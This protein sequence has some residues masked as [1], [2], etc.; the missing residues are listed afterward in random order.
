MWTASAAANTLAIQD[1][2]VTVETLA[3][4]VATLSGRSELHVTSGGDPITGTIIHLNSPDSW[5]FFNRIQPFTVSGSFLGRIRINGAAAATST[6]VRVVQHGN[7]TVVI[8]HGPSFTPLTLFT[9]GRFAGSSAKVPLYTYHNNSNLGALA[10]NIHSFRLKRGYMATMA[11]NENGTGG[12]RVFIAQDDDLDITVMPADL[13][14]NLRFVRVFPW[15]WVSK[16]GWAGNNDSGNPGQVN[17]M[18]FYNWNNNENSGFNREYSPIRQTRWWPSYDI[19]N[20][21]QN[22]TH[23]L[24]FNEPDSPDQADMTVTQAINEWPNLMRSG[25]RLGSPAPTDGGL[26]WLYQFLDQANALNYRVDF[27]AVHFYR[28]GQT[29]T[30]LYNWLRDIHIRTGKPLWVTEWNNGANWTCCAPSSYEQQATIIKSFSEKMDE[31]PFVER[32][33][34]YNWLNGNRELIVNGNLT[35][36]GVAYR[37]HQSPIGHIDTPPLR[38]A[39]VYD[40]QVLQSNSVN[41]EMSYDNNSNW[42]TGIGQ[43]LGA[44]QVIPLS[45]FKTRLAEAAAKG[46][47]GVVDFER[48]ALHDG[49]TSGGSGF[50]AL[51]DDGRKS[52]DFTNQSA[53][54]GNYAIIGPRADRTAISGENSLSRS[55]NPNFD[56]EISNPRGLIRQEK[57][58]AAGLTALG[59]NGVSGTNFFRFTAWYTNGSTSGSTSVRRQINTNTGRGSADTFAGIA[60]PPG[61]WITRITLTS[62]NG[63]FTSIDDL[64]FITSLEPDLL[65]APGGTI[66]GPGVWDNSVTSWTNGG[67]SLAWPGGTIATFADSAGSVD[68]TANVPAVQGLVFETDG[69][70]LTGSGSLSFDSSAAIHVPSGLTTIHTALGG[71]IPAKTGSGTLALGGANNFSAGVWTFGATNTNSGQ[72]RLIHPDALGGL[73]LVRLRGT[74]GPAVSGIELAGGHTFSQ[75]IH[76]WGRQDPGGGGFVLRNLSGNN[77]WNGDITIVDGGG[78]YGFVSAAGRLT[79]G[80]RITSSYVHASFGNRAVP[81]HGAGETRITGSLVNGSGGSNASLRLAVTKNDNGLLSVAPGAV[82][83]VQTFT[84]NA[85]SL[86]LDSPATFAVGSMLLNATMPITVDGDA[87]F[88]FPVNGEGSITKTGSGTLT[89]AAANDFAPDAGTFT[90]GSGATNVGFLRL[91]HPQA[92]GKHTRIVLN[93]SQGGT[94]GLELEG[95]HTFNIALETTGRSSSASTGFAL[96][97]LAGDNI[98]NGSFTITSTGGNYG[99][100]S[101]SGLLTI[102]GDITSSVASTLGSRLLQFAGDGN[103]RLTGQVRKGGSFAAQNLAVSHAGPG[104]LI[105]AAGG[106]YSGSTQVNGGTLQIDGLLTSSSVTVGSDGRLA[107]TGTLPAATVSGRL[108]LV[109]GQTPLTLTGA[110]TLQQGATLEISGEPANSPLVIARYGSRSGNFTSITGLPDGWRL[111]P[112]FESGTAL[113]LIAAAGFSDWA[114]TN[115]IADESFEADSDGDGLPNGLEYALADLDPAAPNGFPG[116]F[117]GRTLSFLKRPEAVANGDVQYLIEISSTLAEGSWTSVPPDYENDQVISYTLPADHERIFMRLAVTLAP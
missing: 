114:S 83:N 103:I 27:V 79:L 23:L 106:D 17:A 50:N 77:N 68:V 85:G 32:Y 25:L 26:N 8:P 55:G 18:W 58:I 88:A 49:L 105:L 30:Q 63:A 19:T 46:F 2:K 13:G 74:Q 48:G 42:T 6:N 3:D 1:R 5:L 97:N 116:T 43:T 100:L 14:T 84:F 33:A 39:A 94:S 92:L 66:G 51:F 112:D 76:T 62:E 16:K 11:R 57:V 93:S 87:I 108:A 47:G 109:A 60:A 7:G 45:Q 59:R 36:A 56:L 82:V 70:S 107:G 75:P 21:K 31:A 4:T 44:A 96:R 22:V 24:G 117:S 10:G 104:T 86:A 15:R 90:L 40:E 89:L 91:S 80:G 52:L 102:T 101:D 72:L 9:Q 73:D 53:N 111:D 95:G 71:E 69:Y 115:G 81:I 113:A 29:A 20:A 37:D 12:S 98:W 34:V 38:L 99:I 64:A 67:Q 65:W 35:A 61:Y 54:S 41:Q 78:S 110:L 28:G